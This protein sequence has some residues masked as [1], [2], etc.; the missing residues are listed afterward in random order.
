MTSDRR[1]ENISGVAKSDTGYIN[2]DI[3]WDSDSADNTVG[4]SQDAEALDQAF[5]EDGQANTAATP[6]S[7]SPPSE[8]SENIVDR[9]L[10]TIGRMSG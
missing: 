5:Q 3:D 8:F 6:A 10:G 9:Q 4:S 2:P 1:R 7:D